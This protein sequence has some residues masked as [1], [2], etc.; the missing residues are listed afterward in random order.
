MDSLARFPM[1]GMISQDHEKVSSFC[2]IRNSLLHQMTEDQKVIM[3]TSFG[4]GE[5]KTH[6]SSGVADSLCEMG[7]K[8]IIC[9][10]DLYHPSLGKAQKGWCDLV[11]N[12]CVSLEDVK[13]IIQAS[14]TDSNVDILPA[15]E[16]RAA[17]PGNLIAHDHLKTILTILRDVYDYVILDTSAVGSHGDALVDGLADVSCIVCRSCQVKK[18]EV[19]YMNQLGETKRLPDPMFIYNGVRAE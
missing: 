10:L 19:E 9:D 7:K 17:A 4:E 13:S 16:F 5:G 8:V 15:G 1:L 6:V 12:N 3:V 11:L 18:S 14:A 2:M